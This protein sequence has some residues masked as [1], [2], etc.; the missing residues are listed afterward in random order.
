MSQNESFTLA[1]FRRSATTNEPQLECSIMRTAP[2]TS[3]CFGSG[4]S[5]V[6]LVE[7][8]GNVV[9][10]GVDRWMHDRLP[11]ERVEEGSGAS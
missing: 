1:G 4:S 10:K 3:R 6:T 11:S 5:M 7:N 2:E 9:K 8:K